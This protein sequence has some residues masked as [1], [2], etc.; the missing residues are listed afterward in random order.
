MGKP[1]GSQKIAS[2]NE[3]SLADLIEQVARLLERSDPAALEAL[4]RSDPRYEQRLR[5][6]LPAIDALS[7]LGRRLS[8][9]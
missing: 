9:S 1:H 3:Q 8:S 2:G 5:D 6:L 4:I 7:R